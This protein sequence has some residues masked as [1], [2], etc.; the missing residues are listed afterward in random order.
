[1]VRHISKNQQYKRILRVRK[2]QR[3]RSGR[4]AAGEIS[5]PSCSRVILVL[6]AWN[7]VVLEVTAER[8][9]PFFPILSLFI[10]KLF[11]ISL[12][13]SCSRVILL[14]A[15]YRVVLEVSAE[16]TITF[17]PFYF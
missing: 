7:R 12:I 5:Y 16:R 17:I 13:P 4:N 11:S 6:N 8:T 2:I 3:E 9:V 1:M 15:W 10:F 14:N